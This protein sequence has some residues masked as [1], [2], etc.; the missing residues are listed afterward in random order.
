[1]NYGKIKI[2]NKKRRA[3]EIHCYKESRC[4]PIGHKDN[5]PVG[6][7]RWINYVRYNFRQREKD[8]QEC[9]LPLQKS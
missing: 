7:L 1:M 2:D 5:W 8:C 3:P 6:L 9:V 4:Y